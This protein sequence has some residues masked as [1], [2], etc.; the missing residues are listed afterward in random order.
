MGQAMA[1]RGSLEGPQIIPE[2]AQP[3]A[4]ISSG[5]PYYSTIM[6]SAAAHSSAADGAANLLMAGISA[7]PS[8]GD[9]FRG[10]VRIVLGLSAAV[11]PMTIAE[12]S[13]PR[14]P[15]QQTRGS[16]TWSSWS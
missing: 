15:D 10:R 8:R 9:D 7:L 4:G 11:R 6:N 5:E 16:A 3:A 2:T 1:V 14:E 13:Y 12:C